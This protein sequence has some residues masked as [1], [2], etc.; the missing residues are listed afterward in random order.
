[1]K[2]SS[3]VVA[4]AILLCFGQASAIEPDNRKAAEELLTLTNVEKNL[5]DMRAQIGQMMTA[6]LQSTNVPENM[7]DKLAQF[8]KQLMDT[9][10][11]ELAFAKMKPVYVDI[12][13]ST[14]TAEELSGLVSFYK[15]PVGRAYANKLPALMKRMMEVAQTKMQTLA[16]RLKKMN[17]DF[18]AELKKGPSPP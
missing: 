15:S 6:Q 12:Y 1:M 14:F 8:Q 9:I 16:P 2:I 4:V 3:T 18:I 17:D 13:S 7:R 5:A 11:E 10:F